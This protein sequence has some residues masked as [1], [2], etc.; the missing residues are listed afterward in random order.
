MITLIP[1]LKVYDF[2]L[3][4]W[5]LLLKREGVSDMLSLA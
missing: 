5:P 2:V 1:L 3:N 4:Y